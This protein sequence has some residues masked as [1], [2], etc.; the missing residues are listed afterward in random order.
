MEEIKR[1]RL[2]SDLLEACGEPGCLLCRVTAAWVRRYL[3]YLLYERVNDP[4][5]RATLRAA[6]GFCVTHAWILTEG[7]GVALGTAIIQRDVLQAVLE[8]MDVGPSGRNGRS[9]AQEILRRL[10]PSTECPACAH[11]R[12]V[13]DAAIQTLLKYL[14][15]AQLAEALRGSSGLCVPHF[16]RALE[17]A[18][19]AEQLQALLD[20]QR[21]ALEAL[22][23]ELSEFIR[24]H[25]YH[26]H[27][28]GFGAES[29]SWIRA[30]GIVS[31]ERHSQ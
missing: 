4:G 9:R 7:F 10:R 6:R 26:F 31:G 18:D 8:A 28:E 13:E 25:D 24:K 1:D 22:N 14:G 15:D 19:S 30:T 11:R 21:A 16:S 27:H 23:A 17:L 20:F 2:Y 12:E 29:N 5:V 3:D